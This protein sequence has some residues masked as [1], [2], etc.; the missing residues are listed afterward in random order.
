MV[1]PNDIILAPSILA[2]DHGNLRESLSIAETCPG[3][4][5]IH[6]DLMDGHFVPNLTFGPQTVA[7]L[8]PHSRLFFDVHLMLARPD[9]FVDA[10]IDAGAE[11]LTIH[12]EP[13]YPVAATL[14]HIRQRG[15]QVGIAIN[16]DT[17]VEDVRPYLH[18]VDLVLLMTVQPGF[19][20]QAFRADVL[21]KIEQVAAW[22][23]AEGLRYHI[24]VDGGVGL[25]TAHSCK[26]A[27]ADTL[28]AGSAFYRADDRAAFSAQIRQ[29]AG[30][31]PSTA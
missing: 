7:D 26:A 15:C 25:K 18:T 21:P 11:N 20:G 9:Q 27:G 10:F 13:D 12:T 19:G 28:V 22:R 29:P 8:R 14:E 30:P 23:E 3:V 4:S 16:P 31:E 5:W 24:E 17:P 6:L 1:T 2:G